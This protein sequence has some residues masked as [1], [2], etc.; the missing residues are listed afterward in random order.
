MTVRYKTVDSQ[1]LDTP[2]AVQWLTYV[3]S[4]FSSVA[5]STTVK[6]FIL[7]RLPG[8]KFK[9]QVDLELSG[10]ADEYA[11]AVDAYGAALESYD[12]ALAVWRETRALPATVGSALTD[13]ITLV[14][15]GITVAVMRSIKLTRGP[16]T[17][18]LRYV[19]EAS[20]HDWAVAEAAGTPLG[21]WVEAIP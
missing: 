13:L 9:A 14:H 5:T 2:E 4:I 6:E 12:G 18:W 21:D 8:S 16:N 19:A 17:S 1:L 3:Q 10:T 11:T 7:Y 15:P 20:A